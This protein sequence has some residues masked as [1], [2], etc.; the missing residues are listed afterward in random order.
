MKKIPSIF[1]RDWDG[2]RR[3][4]LNERNPECQWVFDG[5]GNPTRKWDGTACKVDNGELFARYDYKKKSRD[6]GNKPPTGW[7]PCQPEADEVTGHWPGWVHVGNAPNSKHH[8]KVQEEA[9]TLPDG[10]YELCGPKIGTNPEGFDRLRLLMHGGKALGDVPRDYEGLKAFFAE[11][12]M[13]GIV[14]RHPDG[15][16]A[17]IKAKDLGVAWPP[18]V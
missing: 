5:E 3:Y 11:Y 13:E 12:A 10:T 2:D 4:V 8:R 9:K 17:K 1:V 16:M 18:A 6:K 7:G 14:F 15:R